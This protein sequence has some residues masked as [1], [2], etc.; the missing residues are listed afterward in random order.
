ML[1][2]LLTI[3]FLGGTS[4]YLEM[5]ADQKELIKKYPKFIFIC[6]IIFWPILISLILITAMLVKL[7]IVKLSK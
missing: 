3:W 7:K 6:V 2:L 4:V 1:Y 5:K